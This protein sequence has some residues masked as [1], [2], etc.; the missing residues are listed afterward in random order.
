[1]DALNKE[2]AGLEQEIRELR[3]RVNGEAFSDPRQLSVTP[4]QAR[5]DMKLALEKYEFQLKDEQ[6]K[7]DAIDPNSLDVA[8]KT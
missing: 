7:L 8:E 2:K 6:A 1:M 3:G 5:N 4:L